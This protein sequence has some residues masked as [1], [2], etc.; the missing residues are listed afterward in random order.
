MND[1][2]TFSPS[3]RAL[4]GSGALALSSATFGF[5]PRAVAS[6]DSAKVS[7]EQDG[8]VFRA[9]VK[10]KTPKSG[11]DKR[12]PRPLDSVSCSVFVPRDVKV[13]RGATLNPFYEPTVGQKHW[14]ATARVWNFA[15]IGFNFFG[16][17]QDEQG[18]TALAALKALAKASGHPEL[19]HA[20]LCIHGM[21]I[22]GGLTSRLVAAMPSRVIAA[23]PVCLEVGPRD[24]PSGEVPMVTVF[25]EK[26]GRQMEKLMEKLP[27]AR[28]NHARWAI[29][30]QWKER[31]TWHMA[32]NMVI[33]FY[34]RV[35]AARLPDDSDATDG[36]VQLKPLKESDG[37][38]G[39]IKAWRTPSPKIAPF[40][41]YQG[42]TAAACWLPNAHAA[43][44]WQAFVAHDSPI[45]IESPH[46]ISGRNPFK[47]FPAG[48]PFEVKVA[49][50]QGFTPTKL[51]LYDGDR[52][53]GE[54]DR[55]T[56]SATI[57]PKRG[58]HALIGVATSQDGVK[59]YSSPHA[60]VVL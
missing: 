43:S 41:D 60:L 23:A 50:D 1:Q 44:L 48:E 14:R 12:M 28:G 17:K 33:P 46:G 25:G 31:H 42:D 16:V 38:L 30:P 21:S 51:E 59:S 56:N 13:L 37:W 39:D 49:T 20:P 58:I 2:F 26:D 40:S 35:I 18:E 45:Q 52:L 34:D 11:K 36:P 32:S 47:A 3:R 57:E 6:E 4:V 15:H 5:H 24:K 8:D 22:G 19:E 9:A 55:E 7:S 53:L 54:F 10:L 29:V 27:A